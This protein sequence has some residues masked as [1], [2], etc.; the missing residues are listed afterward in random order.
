MPYLQNNDFMIMQEFIK[1][2]VPACQLEII[3]IMRISIK[4]TTLSD[5]CIA[6]GRSITNQA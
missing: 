5:I 2:K 1:A 4:V 6:E 3:N